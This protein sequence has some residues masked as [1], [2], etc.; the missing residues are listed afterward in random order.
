MRYLASLLLALPCWATVTFQ[1][2]GVTPTQAILDINLSAA[3]G[4]ACLVEV[5]TSPTYS[6]LIND[7]DET[8]FSGAGHTS[9]PGALGAGTPSIQF[10]VGL[11]A[12]LL[13]T[14]GARVS[15]ALSAATT[16]YFRINNDSACDSGGAATGAFTTATIPAGRTSNEA[17]A[18][19][20][21]SPGVA[22]WPQQSG[23]TQLTDPQTGLTIVPIQVP[24]DQIAHATTGV[25][26]STPYDPTGAWGSCAAFP[27]TYTGTSQSKLLLPIPLST[28][29]GG[30]Q[31]SYE[32][33]TWGFLDYLTPHISMSA[34]AARV[35]NFCLWIGG[36]CQGSTLTKTLST[37]PTI[38]TLGA[39]ANG[40][41]DWSPNPMFNGH[42]M[43]Q[44]T[45]SVTVSGLV[46]TAGAG[47]FAPPYASGTPITI[48]GTIYQMSGAATDS[49]LQISLITAPT[50]GTYS[51]TLNPTY[52]AV[53]AATATSQT[54]NIQST[55][56]TWD[57]E[58]DFEAQM[59]SSPMQQGANNTGGPLITVGGCPGYLAFHQGGTYWESAT[60]ASRN[61]LG[62]FV[63]PNIAN[64]PTGPGSSSQLP[65]AQADA[66]VYDPAN[67]GVF[68]T[69]IPAFNGETALVKGIYSGAYG[70]VAGGTYTPVCGSTPCITWSATESSLDARAIAYSAEYAADCC[71]QGWTMAGGCPDGTF[72]LQNTLA[73][74]G[75]AGWLMVY[76][77]ATTS[78][79][80]MR[81]SSDWYPSGGAA[82]FHS[83]MPRCAI[84]GGK[85][86]IGFG[87]QGS[88]LGITFTQLFSG[89]DTFPSIGPYLT[90]LAAGLPNTGTVA[91][92]AYTAGIIAAADWPGG[93]NNPGNICSS[94][95]LAEPAWEDPSPYAKAVTG[96]TV[97]PGGTALTSSGNIFLRQHAGKYIALPDANHLITAYTNAS[98]ISISPAMSGGA[99]SVSCSGTILAEPPASLTGN[100]AYNTADYSFRVPHVGDPAFVDYPTSGVPQPSANT[101]LYVNT[102]PLLFIRMGEDCIGTVVAS[103]ACVQRNYGGTSSVKNWPIPTYLGLDANIN[104]FYINNGVAEWDTVWNTTDDPS[105]SLGISVIDYLDQA[106]H[107]TRSTGISSIKD[108]SG[109]CPVQ[110]QAVGGIAD[111]C[112]LTRYGAN[113]TYVTAP[114]QRTL[115]TAPF[116]ALLGEGGPN[117][118]DTHLAW[119]YA[120]P[121]THISDMRPINGA[122]SPSATGSRVSGSLFHWTYI[123]RGFAS[124]AAAMAADQ[125]LPTLAWCGT[126][127]MLNASGPSAVIDGTSA[128]WYK[129]VTVIAANEGVSGSAPGDLYANCPGASIL[130]ANVAGVADGG[131]KIDITVVPMGA[132][133][134]GL[135]Q[136][137]VANQNLTAAPE[138][139]LGHALALQRW[140]DPFW[141][142]R[143]TPDDRGILFQ[144]IG[145]DYSKSLTFMALPPPLIYDSNNGADY[146]P[147]TV[148]FTAP[149][150]TNQV[151]VEFGY[152]T[153]LGFYCTP[154]AEAC[155]KGSQTDMS[156]AYETTGTW[157]PL[158]CTSTCTIVVPT[159]SGRLAYMRPKFYASG[160]LMRT[161]QTQLIAVP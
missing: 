45:G 138:R 49:D 17:I 68:F 97:A 76:N 59:D 123:Q 99:C 161:G 66:V 90:K 100:P 25:V 48:N 95:T 96:L 83:I 115:L 47:T 144:T 32:I 128:N 61:F 129:Y 23:T 27:C 102:E 16:Y 53:W 64:N 31:P 29:Q 41:T 35:V 7:V 137:D 33:T 134:H 38:Y 139:W 155:I 125:T 121:S 51:F 116:H 114:E 39:S 20:P 122:S 147:Q 136:V 8:Q 127:P 103:F 14:A 94:I 101:Y 40:M 42:L 151:A 91:C 126:H 98:A 146:I 3:L 6:P 82:G 132:W 54:L 89:T 85:R 63:V 133:V 157:T 4:A 119:N 56:N 24:G 117:N 74:Q 130:S 113:F 158:A 46:A 140:F 81:R 141:S 77:P 28:G 79:V 57:Y 118:V 111:D 87:A 135:V 152:D 58:T 55:G 75:A 36:A 92:P 34:D 104:D 120:V 10:P 52:L 80:A 43:T 131:D 108:S 44:R 160:V 84:V 143:F 107:A 142:V 88:A 159:I 112:Y 60:C 124:A 37:S 9:R 156:W 26:F 154:R 21:A 62:Q 109:S 72:M 106:G 148:T 105:G 5:S 73:Q 19:D 30:L 2:A 93:T 11:R 150:G 149:A 15:R 70:A 110:T 22:A 50:A 12:A 13:N 145:A 65:S 153:G 78:V 1:V 69:A 71:S 18:T 86:M 67:A